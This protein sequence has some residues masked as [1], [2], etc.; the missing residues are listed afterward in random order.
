MWRMNNLQQNASSTMRTSKLGPSSILQDL[1]NLAKLDLASLFGSRTFASSSSRVFK[2]FQKGG[3]RTT[4]RLLQQIILRGVLPQNVPSWECMFAGH[5]WSRAQ[6]SKHEDI[7][8][9]ESCRCSRSSLLLVKR[10]EWNGI[11]C[12]HERNRRSI[13]TYPD[14]HTWTNTN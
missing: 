4:S 9:W 11:P 14:S 1:R 8:V 3:H 12:V 2:I 5:C 7:C 13:S 10:T 6:A